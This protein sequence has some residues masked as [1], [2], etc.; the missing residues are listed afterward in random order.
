MKKSLFTLLLFVAAAR[1]GAQEIVK[2]D[3]NNDDE[4]TVADLTSLVDVVIGRSPKQTISLGVD[5]Y[6]VDNTLVIGT[7]Y[8]PDGTFFTLNDDGTTTYSGAATYKFR[9]NL[10][11]LLFFNSNGIPVKKLTVEE[12]EPARYLLTMDYSTNAFTCYT[13][14]ASLAT[15]ITLDQTTLSMNS[16]T[17]AQ[18]TAT[19]SP[20]DAIA[21]ITWTSSDESIATVDQNGLVTAVAGGTCTITAMTNGSNKAASCN[22]TV[23]Q[24]V[25]SIVL[26]QTTATMNPDEIVRLTATVLP[27]NA[28]NKNVIWS[29][30]NE[31][32]AGVVNGTVVAAGGYGTAVITCE[33]AD[34]SGVTSTCIVTVVDPSTYVDPQITDITLDQTSLTMN[35]GT[36]AQLTASIIPA[37]ASASIVWT[38]SDETVATVDQNGLVEAQA[39]GSC[40]I[41]ATT[42]GG[43]KTATCTVSVTQMVTSI[44]LSKT[45]A[46]I[47]LDEALQ[48]TATVLPESAVNKDVIW[49]S[50][51][52][53]VLIVRNG[54]VDT[55]DYGTA[56]VTCEA[57]DGS[58]VKSTCTVTIVDP[59]THTGPYATD[60]TL[61]QT[62]LTMDRA[63]TAQLTAT[64]TPSDALANIT[65]TSSDEA[66]ATVDQNGL[67]RAVS[68]GTCT[69]TAT[70][71]GNHKTATCTVTV[72]QVVTCIVLSQSTVAIE[73]NGYVRLTATVL[74]DNAAN[75]NVVW[76]SSNEAVAT[77]K[78]GRVDACGLGTAIITCEAADGSGVKAT[79][80]CIVYI[81][82]HSTYVD[83]GLPSGTLWATCNVGASSPEDYGDYFAW[84]ETTGY[85]DG[86]TTFDWSTYKWCNGNWDNLTKYCRNGSYGNNGF[87]D[88][89]K[90]LEPADDAAYVN[91]GGVWRMPSFGQ[92]QELINSE[93]TTTT[94]TT[95]NGVNGR[96]ITSKQNGN[97]VFLP[98]AGY[99]DGSSL[100]DAGSH[101]YYMTRNLYGSESLD[102]SCLYF[103]SGYIAAFDYTSGYRCG[104]RSVRPVRSTE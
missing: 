65:W 45:K 13:N 27:E 23:K 3:M 50:S 17:T 101:G 100:V 64:V 46:V 12:V 94:W 38:S 57:A 99:R 98:A 59:S 33:A 21:T 41:T 35:S 37:D 56:V 76:S 55:Y 62:A 103:D 88:G 34:G 43:Q 68:G 40:T 71:S 89:L 86:K 69:I 52:E 79:C 5:P 9:P 48:L 6:K 97:S 54:R 60:I 91:W 14:E 47:A 61:N 16:G 4:L 19:V 95:Q 25:T 24:M 28:D 7:W 90:V 83:L 39:G 102:A 51:N 63:T 93:Y 36:S 78:N 73:P 42:D 67:V 53:D 32:V 81:N 104:G 84:G 1:A 20:D 26:S 85:K 58:G 2:G 11:S 10:G 75:K 96:L 30:D 18:L 82:N 31:A 87:H 77:V 72:N 8:A 49:S 74:P 15:G 44:V 70:T 66:V 80:T 22:V 92:F 29:S